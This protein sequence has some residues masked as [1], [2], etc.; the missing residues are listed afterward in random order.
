MKHYIHINIEVCIYTDISTYIYSN[1]NKNNNLCTVTF[2]IN[3][4]MHTAKSTN[5]LTNI[6][7][8]GMRLRAAHYL[9]TK[10]LYYIYIH[11]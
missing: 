3:T 10:H 4:L 7:T 5:I 9:Y 2:C 1:V 8:D 11:T 6:H